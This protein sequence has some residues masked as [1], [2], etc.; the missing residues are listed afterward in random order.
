MLSVDVALPKG[1]RAA[2]PIQKGNPHKG[3]ECQLT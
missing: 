1:K 2:C 3:L